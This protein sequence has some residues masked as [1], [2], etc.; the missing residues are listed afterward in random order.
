MNNRLSFAP[1]KHMFD[2]AS[3]ISTLPSSEPSL[4]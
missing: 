1:P 2:T 4:A 3:G